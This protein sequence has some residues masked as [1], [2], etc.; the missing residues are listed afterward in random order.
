[1]TGTTPIGNR[2]PSESPDAA[3]LP[4]VYVALQQLMEVDPIEILSPG[5]KCHHL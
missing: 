4:E 3:S 5:A 1:M 2:S